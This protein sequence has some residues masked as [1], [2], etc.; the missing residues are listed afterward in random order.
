MTASL[1]RAAKSGS[2]TESGALHRVAAR[3]GGIMMAWL[4]LLTVEA[5]LVASI[6]RPLFA[7]NWEIVQVRW[8]VAPIA[9]AALLP[10]SLLASLGAEVVARAARDR[11][12]R[13]AVAATCTVALGAL[14]YGVSFGRH[15]RPLSIRLPFVGLLSALGGAL[16]LL[17]PRLVTKI[18]RGALTAT[19]IFV[20]ASAWVA[21]VRILPR[22]YP[23]FH[24][25][26]L[27]LLLVAAAWST[28]ALRA[29]T[30]SYLAFL[31]L[32]L[33]CALWTP[34]AA[35]R[36]KPAENV[37]LV[38]TE[39]TVLMGQAVTLAAWM[40]PP[41]PVGDGAVDVPA[42]PVGEVARALDWEGH[43]ILL[44]SVD[45]LRADHVSSYGYA[46]PTTPNLDA[47]AR[48]GARFQYAYCP[49][50]HTSYSLT[51]LM[52]GKAMRPLLALGLG[53]SSETW[54][55]QLRRYGYRTAAFYPPAVFYIDAERFA[56][57]EENHLDF[58]YAKVQFSSAE[59]RVEEVARY[60]E[61]APRSPLFLWVHLFEPH[62]PYVAHPGYLAPS[63]PES[64]G[65]P[66]RGA[67]DRVADYDSEIAYADAAIGKI[68]ALARARRPGIV[69]MATADHGEEFGEHGGS[70][71]GSTVYEEQVRVP[72][73]VV[74]P[75]VAT[76][77]VNDVA[78]TIDLLPTVLSA[79]G[80]PRP[81]RVRG[82]D[83]GPLLAGQKDGEGGLAYAE[84]DDYA[85][86]ARG[87]ERLICA[88]KASACALYDALR[89][90]LEKDNLAASRPGEAKELRALLYREEHEA[91]RYEAGATPWPDPIRRGLMR[92]ADAAID[93][94]ALLDDASVVIRRKAAEVMFVLGAA[95]VVPQTRR[96][97]ERDEDSDVRAWC[98][99]ALVRNGEPPS[100]TAEALA[101]DPDLAW[102]R[103][104]ALAFA[105]QGDGRGARE[106]AQQFADEAPPRGALDVGQSKELIHAFAKIRDT[107]AVPGL[108]KALPFVPLR[109]AI[110][111][112]LGDIGD[113]RATSALLQQFEHESYDAARSH[114]ARALVAL[115]ARREILP[116][117]R[118]FAGQ[119]EP[120][121]E[122]LAIARDAGLLEAGSG[123]VAFR[124][125]QDDV[126]ARLEVALPA[127]TDGAKGRLRLLVLASSEGGTLSGSVDGLPLESGF[128]AGAVHIRELPDLPSGVRASGG[129][130]SPGPPGS[131]ASLE[132][133]LRE[134][135]GILA[136][137]AVPEAPATAENRGGVDLRPPEK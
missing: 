61:L 10:L 74:G 133:S 123:G 105:L 125:P 128:E 28:A 132:L 17:L 67:R 103:R 43:D 76:K 82:R 55:A 21:D 5:T 83:L 59:A 121:V 3:A 12:A 131:V 58:E 113:E 22:L 122:S 13:F 108:L 77:T 34:R 11:H 50:P 64:G 104:A 134:T 35:E 60:L 93:A 14:A 44:V 118:E 107:E 18:S 135:H 136:I 130:K 79:L 51:S 95:S 6:D 73:V 25:G 112:A 119:P 30:S 56:P 81:A 90:P 127:S 88:R 45:A 96:A 27:V 41:P 9:F 20:A 78:Q 91:G 8:L 110:A 106:L 16:G 89:D 42:A 109:S 71:H 63:V 70:F 117:L 36:L 102:R 29:R 2:S 111:D 75:G 99:L 46:K 33:V 101:R 126:E 40:A 68:V 86:V 124:T 39:H 24:V 115:G 69:V 137:W 72:L 1:L 26:L 49:T 57:F 100:R 37:R 48:E 31:A 120:M 15:M 23:A 54:A 32:G 98:A 116:S 66:P 7:G 85:L 129:R 47:L 80:I 94:A 114:E 38:L 84:T 65:A 53:G 52:T 19:G 92:D 97:L 87:A 62:E 4:V